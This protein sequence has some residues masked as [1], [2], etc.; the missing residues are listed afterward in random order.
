MSSDGGVADERWQIGDV[1][2]TKVH[3]IT[4][5]A[6]A[7]F[8]YEECTPEDLERDAWWTRPHHIDDEGN[9][10]FSHHSLVV[11]SQGRSIVVDTCVG[12]GRERPFPGYGDLATDFME[13]FLGAGFAPADVDVVLCTHL[14]FDHVGWNTTLV[15]SKW[16][17]TFPNARYLFGR[18]EY[19]H[20][21]REDHDESEVAGTSSF[22]DSVR[23]V[24][25]AGLMDLVEWDHRITDEVRLTPSPGHT[26]GHHSVVIESAGELAVI[27]GDCVHASIHFAHPEWR[28]IADADHETAVETRRRVRDEWSTNDALV[29]GT[30]FPTP[31]S[32]HLRND[33]RGWWFDTTSRER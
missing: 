14:H 1:T 11:E 27:T 21:S 8:F 25:E 31:S 26:P 7:V 5:P 3:E 16:V 22:D 30:H 9:V 20:W 17:P 15:D 23:P 12:N 18:V 6:P 32:G 2:I 28:S 10:L 13:R 29:I 4:L 33:D 19:E 24:V